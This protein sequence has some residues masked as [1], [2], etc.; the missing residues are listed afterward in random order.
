MLDLNG[1]VGVLDLIMNGDVLHGRALREH[2]YSNECIRLCHCRILF[3]S[4]ITAR[5]FTPDSLDSAETSKSIRSHMRLIGWREEG[6]SIDIR[7]ARQSPES[8]VTGCV[9]FWGPYILSKLLSRMRGMISA[10]GK[11]SVGKSA[12]FGARKDCIQVPFVLKY[13][14]A[15]NNCESSILVTGEESF[16]T[17][18]KCLLFIKPVRS[19]SS[20]H[21]AGT[22]ALRTWPRRAYLQLAGR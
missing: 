19:E 22:S 6:A 3:A 1:D 10:I 2:M 8:W 5:L 20:L 14:A 9:P 18:V 21:P 16:F 12:F 11:R 15:T 13:L 4:R 17:N 7:R